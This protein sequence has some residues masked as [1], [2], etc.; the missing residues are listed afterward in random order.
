MSCSRPAKPANALS[1]RR[2]FACI[3]VPMALGGSHIRN[4]GRKRPNP[5]PERRR[6]RFESGPLSVSWLSYCDPHGCE[7]DFGSSQAIRTFSLKGANR[8]I[9]LQARGAKHVP[10]GGC[11][12]PP[13]AVPFV[14]SAMCRGLRW[15]YLQSAAV[16]S[17]RSPRS[18]RFL[19]ARL[20]PALRPSEIIRRSAIMSI[21]SVATS[22]AEREI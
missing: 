9:R 22:S 3:R 7:E 4:R 15:R 2:A 14:G 19:T 12:G 17:R 1:S 10:I 5:A 11:P 18:V 8:P 6:S 20:S 16:P 21:A 13:D